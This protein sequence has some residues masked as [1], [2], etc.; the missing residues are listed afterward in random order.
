MRAN[1][2][3]GNFFLVTSGSRARC[4]QHE[5]IYIT[6]SSTTAT[7]A[8]NMAQIL[9]TGWQKR[10]VTGTAAR[11]IETLTYLDARLADAPCRVYHGVH[12]TNVE[13]GFSAFGELDF[14]IIAPSGR[15][16]L[17]SIL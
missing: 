4:L 7:R 9:P 6:A 3:A 15:L 1:A 2:I 11:E 10:A 17:L 16:L 14:I 13:N 5:H 8:R 12:W